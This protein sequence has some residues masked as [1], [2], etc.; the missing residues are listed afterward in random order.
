MN[1]PKNQDPVKVT[2]AAYDEIAG[3]Y[4][5]RHR[6]RDRY[7]A[8]MDVFSGLLSTGALVFDIGSGPGMEAAELS[9]R[10]LRVVC[11]DLSFGMLEEGLDEFPSVRVQADMRCLP[12]GEV[13]DGLWVASSLH[14]LSRDAVPVACEEFRRVLRPDGALYVCVREGEGTGW[15]TPYGEP[16]PRFFSYWKLPQLRG[17][18][19]RAGFETIEDKIADGWVYLWGRKIAHS[20]V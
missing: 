6:G 13:A 17:L 11:I 14:H 15:E 4:L 1:P 7:G 20:A 2:Q 18:L 19:S 12:F 3:D 5:A 9:S 10:A 8:D 16:I